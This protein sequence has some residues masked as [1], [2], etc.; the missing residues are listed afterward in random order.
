MY[1]RAGAP[2]AVSSMDCTHLY[3]RQ[4]PVWMSNLCTGKEGRPTLSFNCMVDHSRYIQ[5]VSK[6]F[7]GASNDIQVVTNDPKPA[8]MMQ[9]LL[10]SIVFFLYLAN[11]LLLMCRGAYVIVD[12][13]YPKVC[14]AFV[15]V[16]LIQRFNK[17]TLDSL[18]Y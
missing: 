10:L 9:G 5:H 18:F 13:G 2:G 12:G 17:Y 8:S 1:A 11:G 14:L 6:G 15:H 7:V 16:Y 4:C 3:W